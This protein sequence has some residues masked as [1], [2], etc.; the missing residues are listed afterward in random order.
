MGRGR[1]DPRAYQLRPSH[2]TR[3]GHWAAGHWLAEHAR[4]GDVVL[5]TRGWARFVSGAPGYDYWHV[6][7]ALTD[8]HLSYVVVGHEEL[9][10]QQP[11][12]AERSMRSWRTRPPRSRTSRRWPASATS[13][14][15]STG[16][17][18]PTRGRD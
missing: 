10:G 11:A 16:S 7:Q 15:G 3:W 14:C 4:P 12:G 13:A 6:R 9:D 8:S 1:R 2:P 17:T 18:G 5:D